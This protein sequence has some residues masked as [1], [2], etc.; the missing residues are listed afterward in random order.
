MS[1]ATNA[2]S[3]QENQSQKK[4]RFGQWGSAWAAPLCTESFRLRCVTVAARIMTSDFT[5]ELWEIAQ[6][7]KKTAFDHRLGVPRIQNSSLQKAVASAALKKATPGVSRGPTRGAALLQELQDKREQG[8]KVKF[9]VTVCK[10]I[11][12]GKN[13][14]MTIS[15]IPNIRPV[16][17]IHEDEQ[18]YSA[19][20]HLC[21]QVQ[22]YHAQLFP[23]AAKIRR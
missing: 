16:E 4:P 11:E 23:T 12:G 3:L 2:K 20:D 6:G 10:S 1:S 19:L 18:I 21:V 8:K 5:S 13:G 14:I 22:G 9:T 15:P 7:Y 17:N